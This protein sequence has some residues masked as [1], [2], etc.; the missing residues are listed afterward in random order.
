MVAT[1][2]EFDDFKR[3]HQLIK[4]ISFLVPGFF[5]DIG[6]RDFAIAGI[7]AIDSCLAFPI[8]VSLGG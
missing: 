6:K 2:T 4:K 3:F 8:K 1:S 7:D 5:V